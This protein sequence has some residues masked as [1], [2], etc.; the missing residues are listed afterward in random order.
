MSK[1]KRKKKERLAAND[2]SFRQE[3]PGH[4]MLLTGNQARHY[5]PL[6]FILSDAVQKVESTTKGSTDVQVQSSQDFGDTGMLDDHASFITQVA[7]DPS[8][9][10]V[11]PCRIPEHL[12]SYQENLL[13]QLGDKNNDLL[14]NDYTNKFEKKIFPSLK[15]SGR[16]Q[17]VLLARL[18]DQ[19]LSGA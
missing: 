5:E 17:V 1:N 4:G 8:A 19:M 2:V 16:V 14:Y 6:G 18:L 7:T 3:K 12:H 15:P 11:P 9:G 13:A 10:Q